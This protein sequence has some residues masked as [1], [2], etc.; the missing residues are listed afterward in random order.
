[1]QKNWTM[2][3]ALGILARVLSFCCAQ[4]PIAMENFCKEEGLSDNLSC[5]KED[6]SREC[7]ARSELCNKNTFCKSGLDEGMSQVRL[8]CKFYKASNCIA[9]TVF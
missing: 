4:S 5:E 7:F 2:L 8:D 9:Y 6:G 3:V 1:M